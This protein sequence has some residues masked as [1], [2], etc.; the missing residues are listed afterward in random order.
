MWGRLHR[1]DTEARRKRRVERLIGGR[2]ESSS[3]RPTIWLA[4]SDTLRASSAPPLSA[5]NLA[6]AYL[7]NTMPAEGS[8]GNSLSRVMYACPVLE[9]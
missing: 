1:G 7:S 5:V 4:N 9:L 2:S 3:R 6:K 8:M